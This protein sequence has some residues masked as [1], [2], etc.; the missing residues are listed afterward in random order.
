MKLT[1]EQQQEIIEAAKRYSEFVDSHEFHEDVINKYENEI[2]EIVMMSIYG[3]DFYE[4][5]NKKM[6]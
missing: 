5:I 1:E 2:I 3:E 6:F 4:R